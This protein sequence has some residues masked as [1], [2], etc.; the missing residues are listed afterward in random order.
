MGE[1]FLTKDEAD[2]GEIVIYQPDEI[3]KLEVRID[4]ILN[5][6]NEE[7]RIT[8]AEY[9]EKMVEKFNFRK[10]YSYGSRTRRRLF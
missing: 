1:E 9:K 4:N 6:L 5:S 10:T 8:F 3:T 7:K 2:K